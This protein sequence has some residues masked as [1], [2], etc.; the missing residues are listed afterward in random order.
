MGTRKIDK[1]VN[2]SHGPVQTKPQVG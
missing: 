2:Y 1:Q